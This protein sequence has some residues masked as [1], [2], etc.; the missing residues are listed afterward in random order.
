MFHV[1][2]Q[3]AGRQELHSGLAHR[4]GSDRFQRAQWST[5]RRLTAETQD[6]GAARPPIV[7][8]S[9]GRLDVAV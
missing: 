8:F 6:V 7:A 9:A 3:L 4:R 2:P 1:K 5:S